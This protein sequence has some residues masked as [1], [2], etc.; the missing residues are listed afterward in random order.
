MN[1]TSISRRLFMSRKLTFVLTFGLCFLFCSMASGQGMPCTGQPDEP[2]Q[3]GDIITCSITAPGATDTFTFNGT[4]GER[5]E[6]VT[7]SGSYAPC[8]ELVGVGTACGHNLQAWIDTVLTQTR[9]YTIEAYDYFGNGTLNYTLALQRV[10]PPSPAA[11]QTT[12]GQ[13]LP[14]QI[15]PLGDIVPYY[16]TASLLDVVQVT[17]ASGSYAPCVFL[18]APDGTTTWNGCGHNLR[19]GITTSPLT[20]AGNYSILV[21]DYFPN[22]TLSYNLNLQCLGGTCA[23]T[24]IPDVAGYI[25]L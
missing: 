21:Y 6:I 14:G 9:Q 19:N 4:A 12:Y 17:I 10:V 7:S 15:N 2:I 5:V 18:Y 20:L 1:E 13:D 22:D 11:T 24:I 25:I 16:F 8:I 23:V 3:Y